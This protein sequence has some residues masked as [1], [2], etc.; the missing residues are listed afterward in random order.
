MITNTTE[1]QN[2]KIG[3]DEEKTQLQLRTMH[4]QNCVGSAI[5]NDL[6]T[7][8]MEENNPVKTIT[9]SLQIEGEGVLFEGLDLHVSLQNFKSEV[10]SESFFA[11][12]I[13]QL[14]ASKAT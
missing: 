11:S 12:I 13:Q 10:V 1:I 7:P 4:D 6:V 9:I 3:V 5:M 8:N 14:K 2:E